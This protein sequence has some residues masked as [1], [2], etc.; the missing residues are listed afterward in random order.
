MSL[1]R[2]TAVAANCSGIGYLTTVLTTA[3]GPPALGRSPSLCRAQQRIHARN[4][5]TLSLF[6]HVD[7]RS[8]RH[9]NRAVKQDA[10]HR[11][12]LDTY[13]EQQGRTQMPKVVQPDASHTSSSA[14]RVERSVD[15]PRLKR[16]LVLREYQTECVGPSD[17]HIAELV[18]PMSPQDA[19]SSARW[20]RTAIVV[21]RRRRQRRHA[22]QC[23]CR[24]T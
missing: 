1:R 2:C 6:D 14:Q 20:F 5:R 4:R 18:T 22:R 17:P 9:R 12:C 8:C 7:V 15:V 24:R 23:G 3:A 10:L 16:C 19:T 11:C 13:H 21:A